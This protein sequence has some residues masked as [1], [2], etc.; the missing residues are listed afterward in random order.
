[1]AL[2]WHGHSTVCLNCVGLKCWRASSVFILKPSCFRCLNQRPSRDCYGSNLL[3]QDFHDSAAW[4]QTVLSE[5]EANK[6]M[7]SPLWGTYFFV[8]GT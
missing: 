3:V 1:M 4:L 7:E 6:L 5:E 8:F 2:A